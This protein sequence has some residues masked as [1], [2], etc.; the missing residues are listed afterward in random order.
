[1]FIPHHQN[2]GRDS[3][4]KTAGKFLGNVEKVNYFGTIATRKIEFLNKLKTD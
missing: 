1:M 4:V 2:I 3:S